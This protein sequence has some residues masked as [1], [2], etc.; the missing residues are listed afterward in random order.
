[1]KIRPLEDWVCLERQEYKHPRLYIHGAKTHRGTIVAI[2][3]GAWYR[4]KRDVKDP[5]TGKIFRTG[6]G[7]D[8]TGKRVPPSGLEVGDFVEFSDAG[9][10]E[11]EIDGKKYVFTKVPSII[12]FADPKDTQGFQFHTSP[13]YDE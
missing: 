8:Q 9:W 13:D 6:A 2:G 10:Q 1:M 12:C 5:L 3:P 11:H 4:R 7:G